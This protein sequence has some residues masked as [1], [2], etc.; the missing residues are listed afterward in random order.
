MIIYTRVLLRLEWQ[1]GRGGGREGGSEGGR[2]G[3]RDGG[4]EDSQEGREGGREGGKFDTLWYRTYMQRF[5]ISH[6]SWSE[7]YGDMSLDAH[8]QTNKTG[9][10]TDTIKVLELAV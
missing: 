2:E 1:G 10:H 4:R 9:I 5:I 6:S 7:Q 3:G 8:K